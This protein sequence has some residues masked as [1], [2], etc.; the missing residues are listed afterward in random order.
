M[1]KNR[2]LVADPIH[3]DAVSLLKEGGFDVILR[4]DISADDLLTTIGEY[5]ALVVR[6]RTKVTEPVIR[7]GKQLRVIARSGVGLD[8][9]DLITAK[10][11]G[12]QV[13]NSPEGP[14]VSVAELVFALALSVLR[15]VSF[16]SHGML[17]GEWLK[18]AGKG[19]ELRGKRLGI[20]GFGLIGE[21]VAKRAIA[22]EMKVLAFD[23]LPER[24]E[25]MKKMGVEYRSFPD[26]LAESDILTVHL[27]LTPKTKGLIGRAEISTMPRGA[28]IIN[29]SRGGIVNEQALYD[30]LTSGH[31]GGAGLDVFSEEP[32]FSNDLLQKLLV[33]PNVVST[34]HIGAQTIEASRANSMVI[35]QKLLK[36]LE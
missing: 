34:P 4:T 33:H 17:K 6:G 23:I 13:I 30:C 22:F 2:I 24:V 32:P 15:R 35:A 8:N 10:E 3:E 12:V 25:V 11:V 27:P 21:A 26:L 5:D 16:T 9:I 14:S 29:T 19:R 1:T 36:L 20:D 7:A 18:K 28:I 31:L